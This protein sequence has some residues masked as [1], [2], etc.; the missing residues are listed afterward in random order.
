MTEG[1]LALEMLIEFL[2]AVE[3]GV[4]AAKQ[5]L[6]ERKGLEELAKQIAAV[7]EETFSILTFESHKGA[8]LGDYEVAFKVN[9]IQ[10]KWVHAYNVLGLSNSTIRSRYLGPDYAYSYW[11][12]GTDKIYRQKLKPA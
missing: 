2:N 9:N 7:K 1:D 11:I 5:R 12:F 4:A 8:K 10:E 6:K 3:A